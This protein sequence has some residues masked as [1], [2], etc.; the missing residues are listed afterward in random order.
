MATDLLEADHLTD[1]AAVVREITADFGPRDYAECGRA[2]RPQ[3]G[4]W[5]ALGEAGFIGINVPEEF[6]GGGAGMTELATVAVE[7]AAGGCPL[8]LLLVSSAIGTEVLRRH[9]TDAQRHRWLP[10]MADGSTVLA[11]AVTEPDAGSNSHKVTTTAVRDGADWVLSGSKYYISGIDHAAAVLVVARTGTDPAT[12]RAL[13]TLFLVPTDSPGLSWQPLPVG[14]DIPDRQF[15]VYLDDVRLGAD[16]VIGAPDGGLVPLFDGLNP[17]RITAAALAVGIGRYA[18]STAAAYASG[19]QVWDAPLATHQ[20]VAHPL[21]K[22]RIEVE[23]AALMAMR[24]AD[25]HDRG[26]PAG[27]AANMAKYA[28]A[29]AALAAVEAAIQTHGGNGLSDEYGLIPLWGMARLLQIAPVNRE[30]VLNY[31]ARH[32]LG[33]PRAY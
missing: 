4:L 33:M 23:L 10:G 24:A 3:T 19:R 28:A 30:M 22:A 9:G 18:T 11:F 7:S 32:T 15:T 2:G 26:L 16:A 14:I 13:L 8:L 6:G 27:E 31:V 17:E 21:A 29:E 1:I 20:G 5:T 12:G 25:L